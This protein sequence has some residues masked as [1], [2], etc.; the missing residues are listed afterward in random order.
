[1]NDGQDHLFSVLSGE[2]VPLMV[3][4][5]TDSCSDLTKELREKYDIEYCRMNTIIK[6]KEQ[7]ASLDWE[8]YTPK[9]F[10]DFMRGGERITTTQVPAQ[11]FE[12]EFTKWLEKGCDIV[13]IGCSSVLSG[14]VEM[15]RVTAEAL[16]KQYPERK[17]F[18]INSLNA[19]M[20]EGLLAI[21]AAEYR[22][23][24]FG[25]EEIAEKIEAV[26]NNVNQFC[27]VHSLEALRRAGR[28]KATAAFFGN[29]L[30]VKPII[31]SNKDGN[32]EPIKKV[33]GRINSMREIV[34]LT[35]ENIV[36]PE[37]QTVYICHADSPDDASELE[38]M[39]KESIPGVKT[40]TCYIGPII[41]ASIGPDAIALLSFGENV[42][43]FSV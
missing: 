3:K 24:G 29:L 20:G 12:T 13:Y 11:E 30:G 27:T 26:R 14:S 21:K 42:E 35:A 6:G 43:K 8:Y 1:M 7:P 38:R 5:F 23:Q 9:K 36:E 28:V 25:A 31:I 4:I 40:Y 39:L 34:R 2:G 22:D 15:G 10:Y 19:C 41:G 37:N 17:I 32:N 18:C 33:K 16:L